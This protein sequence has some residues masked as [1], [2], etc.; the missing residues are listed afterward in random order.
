[1][2]RHDARH[3]RTPRAGFRPPVPQSIE[4]AGP[5]GTLE[6]RV[7]D[8]VPPGAAHAVVGVVCHPHPLHGGTMQNKVVHTAARAMQEA[9]AA[10]VRFNFRGVGRSEGR[11]DG[12]R[13]RTRGCAGSRG[14][15]TS[16]VPVRRALAR[17]LFVRRGGGAAGGG[18]WRAAAAARHDRA[19]GRPHHHRAG[20]SAGVCLAD[21][22]GRSRRTGR[23]RGR[24]P[25]GVRLR[26][27]AGSCSS[28][29]DAEHFFHGKLLELR[30]GMVRFL[31]GRDQ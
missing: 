9:G 10:T 16:A 26:P 5:A 1:M 3:D 25:L 19:A 31:R 30:A 4:I 28:W 23:R 24:A 2:T 20:R 13:R 6:A 17:R 22:A 15:G 29:P 11:Y 14:L 27:C 7:E 12:R 18:A 8:P 21:R